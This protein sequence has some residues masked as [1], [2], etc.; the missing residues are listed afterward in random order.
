MKSKASIIIGISIV[1]VMVALFFIPTNEFGSYNPKSPPPII[2]L[3]STPDDFKINPIQC[4]IESDT[5]VFGF[6]IE[7]KLDEDYRLEIHLGLNDENDQPLSKEAIL[8]ETHAGE[9]IIEEHETPFNPDMN[10]C[11]IELKRSEKIK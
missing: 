6:A 9:T 10:T 8:V 7:N 5:V 1:G 2:V 11:V 4:S 3:S